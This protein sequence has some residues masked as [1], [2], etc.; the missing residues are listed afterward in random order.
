MTGSPEKKRN[1]LENP[2]II[3]NIRPFI[4]Y[5]EILRPLDCIEVEKITHQCHYNAITLHPYNL[6]PIYLKKKKSTNA[7]QTHAAIDH[8]LQIG[9]GRQ[10]L[11]IPHNSP[12]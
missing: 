3:R 7:P 11:A 2:T 10:R 12:P 4:L 1:T 6:F 5:T 9:S 8:C